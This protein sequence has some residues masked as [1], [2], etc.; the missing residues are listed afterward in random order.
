MSLRPVLERMQNQK[1]KTFS[2]EEPGRSDP[3]GSHPGPTDRPPQVEK[4][5]AYV[6]FSQ[7]DKDRALGGFL[8]YYRNR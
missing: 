7:D 2:I 4:Y 6:G 8:L 1:R 5:V 3:F